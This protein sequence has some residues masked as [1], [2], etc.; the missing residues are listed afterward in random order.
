MSEKRLMELQEKEMKALAKEHSEIKDYPL[1]VEN[2]D[3]DY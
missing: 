3:H 2:A 1:I